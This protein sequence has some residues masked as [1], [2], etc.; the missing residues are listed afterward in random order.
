MK[1]GTSAARGAKPP[2]GPDIPPPVEETSRWEVVG[3]EVHEF[4][5]ETLAIAEDHAEHTPTLTG[6]LVARHGRLVLERYYRGGDLDRAGP[7]F[8]VTKSVVSALV[9]IALRDGKLSNLNAKLVDYLGE[10]LSARA[11]PRV[12]EIKLRDLLTMTAG[13]QSGPEAF[14]GGAAPPDRHLVQAILS[15]RM[16]SV[17]GSRFAYDNGAVHLVSAILTRATGMSAA[18]YASTELFRPLGIDEAALWS[19]DRQGNSHG[20]YGLQLTG[21]DLAKLG[22]L[23]L[24]AGQWRGRS[25]IP[26]PYVRASTKRQ[27]PVGDSGGGYGY[28]WWTRAAR[29]DVPRFFAAAGYGGQFVACVPKH[30]LVVVTT[31]NASAPPGREYALLF[32][33]VLAAVR[34]SPTASA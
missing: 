21:R 5:G 9:G 11:D 7:A 33:R 8:S 23:Y 19:A 16:A 15:R 24:R 10:D 20:A 29:K 31:S 14:T 18:A 27:V 1:R 6:I 32:R 2:G 22:Q 26:A 13:F 34:T 30:D 3:P 17:P 25:L 28:L 4:D 12:S